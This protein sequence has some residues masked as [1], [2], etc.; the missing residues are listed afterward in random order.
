MKR[1][2]GEELNPALQQLAKLCL[3]RS[4]GEL[5]EDRIS[6]ELGFVDEDGEP[7]REAMYERLESWGIPGW[8]A[9][10]DEEGEPAGTRGGGK[11]NKK[12]RKARG[13]GDEVELPPADRAVDLFRED[14]ERLAQYLEELPDLRE[15]YQ[16]GEQLK[17]GRFVWWSWA[18]E[19]WDIHCKEDHLKVREDG[20][21]SDE[22]W[23]ALCEAWGEDPS[24]DAIRVP[25]DPVVPQGAG[26]N[27]WEGLVPLIA[28]HAV[29]SEEADGS[30]DDLLNAL[31]PDPRSVDKGKL[32][33]DRA[34][35]ATL[36]TYAERLARLVRGAKLRDGELVRGHLPAGI[37]DLDHWV[38]LNL[39]APRVEMGHTDRQIHTWMANKHPSL[40]ELYPAKEIARLRRL[41]LPPP[42]RT[43]L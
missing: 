17:A 41:R 9:R 11:R 20:S 2:A 22:R 33:S 12:G 14:L 37:P 28:V 16:V 26:P 43:P 5:T 7:L 18:G 29:L 27:P 39:V 32:Y 6:Q 42:D 13:T 35:P 21:V 25:I 38:A 19:D 10:P 8:V 1:L 36:R 30:V 15:Q 40:A 23:V 31:H 24:E 3:L 34:I 4:R